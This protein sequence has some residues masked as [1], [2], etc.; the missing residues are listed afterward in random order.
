MELMRNTLEQ[1]I[2]N[3][4]RSSDKQHSQPSSVL[5]AVDMLVQLLHGLEWLHSG[6]GVMDVGM[7]HSDIKPSNIGFV[8]SEGSVV[9]KLMDFGV[10]KNLPKQVHE[11]NTARI[12][13]TPA[14]MSPQALLGIKE[15]G[16]DI[17]SLGIVASILLSG[18][19][20]PSQATASAHQDLS[21]GFV[22]ET[23]KYAIFV[24]GGDKEAPPEFI[25]RDLSGNL[26]D[27][28][29][30][31]RDSARKSLSGIVYKMIRF[32]SSDRYGDSAEVLS[33]LEEWKCRF[34]VV[35]K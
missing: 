8:G 32:S 29:L 28:D 22:P 34:S 1:N 9:W 12:A 20:H 27:G 7:I 15:K 30:L 14:Y 25:R 13:G 2:Q 18:W 24:R 6:G 31:D 10:S 21:L 17:Y 5:G 23:T 3:P 35:K 4:S 33:D 19:R 11:E 26:D 16:N